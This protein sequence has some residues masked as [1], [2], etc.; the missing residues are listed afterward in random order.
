[1]KYNCIKE[2]LVEKGLKQ[3]YLVDRL[4][5]N[6]TTVSNWCRQKTQPRG[7]ML[8]QIAEVLGVEPGDLIPKSLKKEKKPR[9]RK[10]KARQLKDFKGI[11]L[12]NIRNIVQLKRDEISREEICKELGIERETLSNWER[13]KKNPKLS[14]F[15]RLAIIL[16]CDVAD[17]INEDAKN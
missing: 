3:K 12:N 11:N 1:M 14:N 7:P 4:P 8:F 17:L 5:V 10:S 2:I 6:H 9:R 13:N 15:F 16:E